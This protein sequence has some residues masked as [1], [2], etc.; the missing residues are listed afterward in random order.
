M[1]K[2]VNFFVKFLITASFIFLVGCNKTPMEKL[3]SD[4]LEN[5][6]PSFWYAEAN[7]KTPLW[8]E[9]VEYCKKNI[10]KPNCGHVMTIWVI[11]N[12]STTSPGIGHSGYELKIPEFK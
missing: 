5:D 1:K 8:E 11:R 7:E 4:H 3:A 12:G 9:A 2:Q 6:L 10:H